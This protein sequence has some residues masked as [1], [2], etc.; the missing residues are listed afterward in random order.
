MIEMGLFV[1]PTNLTQYDKGL[2]WAAKVRV[3]APGARL[4]FW[5]WH[6]V[7]PGDFSGGS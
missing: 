2:I 5:W 6:P 4:R 7:W 3:S 1:M